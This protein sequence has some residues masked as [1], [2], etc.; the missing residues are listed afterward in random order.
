MGELDVLMK[1]SAEKQSST[2]NQEKAALN[3]KAQT[4]KA[5]AEYYKIANNQDFVAAVED[6][7]G[8]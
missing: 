1:M 3:Q 8:D 7:R 4:A 6:L 5:K 2:N